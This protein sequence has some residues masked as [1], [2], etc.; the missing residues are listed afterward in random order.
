MRVAILSESPADEAA[1]RI[2]V[3]R[4]I[5]RPVEPLRLKAR[6]RVL[7]GGVATAIKVLPAVIAQL[8]YERPADAL[9]FVVDSNSSPVHSLCGDQAC[10]ARLCALTRAVRRALDRLTP[11]AGRA[12]VRVA[13][14]LAVPAIEAWYLCGKVPSVSES[15]WLQGVADRHL[16]YDRRRLK[17][18]VYGTHAPRLELETRCA[19]EA[20]QRVVQDLPLLEQKFPVGFGA[21]AAGLRNW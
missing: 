15:A 10:K 19:S 5:R 1:I 7:G 9:A 6:L 12:A 13:V 8:H 2:L 4:V 11:L 3:E 18:L 20:M 17:E 21:L 16:P 14:G